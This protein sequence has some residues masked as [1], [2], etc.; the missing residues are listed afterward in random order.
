MPPVDLY[1]LDDN[2]ALDD[3]LFD[4]VTDD[5]KFSILQF[6]PQGLAWNPTPGGLMDKLFCALSFEPSRVERR[7]L[8]LLEEYDPRTTQEL[9][10]DWERVLD[11]PGDCDPPGTQTDDER[12]AAVLAKLTQQAFSSVPF[13]LDLASDLGYPSAQIIHEHDPFECGISVCGDALKGDEGHWTYTWTLITGATSANDAILQCL[14]REAAQAH[15]VVHFVYPGQ[16]YPGVVPA[17][18]I[19]ENPF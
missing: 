5:Y 18:F 17:D 12:R 15:V 14:V 9:L 1:A 4:V 8:D 16:T 3:G 6:L 2:A 10:E 11:L 19:I 7:G 13:F